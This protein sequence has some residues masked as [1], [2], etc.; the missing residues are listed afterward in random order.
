M[1]LPSVDELKY[2][3][4]AK[5]ATEMSPSDELLTLKL[6]YK[7]PDGDTSKKLEFPVVDNGKPWGK[8]SCDFRFAA[9]VASFGMILRDSEHKGDTSFDAVTEWAQEGRGEDKSG[10]RKEFLALVGKAAALKPVVSGQ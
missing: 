1:D 5:R 2:Q 4:T 7:Q 9:A 8:A 10:Y 6:R 3:Q